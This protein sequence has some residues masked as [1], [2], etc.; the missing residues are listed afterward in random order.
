MKTRKLAAGGPEVGEIGL[1]CMSFGGAFGDT[2]D[3]TTFKCMDA[4]LAAGINFWDTSDVYGEGWSERVIGDYIRATGAKPVIATKV[5]IVRGGGFDNSRDYIRAGLERSLE[6]LGVDR[7]ELYYIHRREAERPIEEVVET[8]AGLIEEGLIGGYGLSEVSP[9]SLRRAQKVHPC[10][11]VQSEYSLWTR[12]PE[13]GML[14]A[15][16]DLDVTFVPFS[17]VARGFL[18][19]GSVSMEVAQG[20]GFRAKMPRFHAPNYGYNLEYWRE[21]KAFCDA[22]DWPMAA[23]ALAWLLDRDPNQIPIP[24]TRTAEHLAEWLPATTLALSDDDRAEIDRILP[25]GW[26]HGD[27]Y[28]DSQALNVERYC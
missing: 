8:M 10:M 12:T 25:P 27:R 15:C 16:A 11:A 26:A 20:D 23:V 21:F 1:G 2:D 24:A 19:D 28:W 17:P 3:A 18:T 6:R 5:G 13:L 22:R 14:R 7:V 4:A 9:A